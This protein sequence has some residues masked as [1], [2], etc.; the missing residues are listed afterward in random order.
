MPELSVHRPLD[1]PDLH[2]DLGANPMAVT[3]QAFAVRERRL[4]D[5]E[6]VETPSQIEQELGI[7]AGADLAREREV[8]AVMVADEQRAEADSGALRIG[9]PADD[10][11]L[12]RFDFHLEPV[13]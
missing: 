8:V 9:E 5:R 11:F 4:L 3:G 2:D 6:S 7:E 12:R 10:K 1:E 13:L